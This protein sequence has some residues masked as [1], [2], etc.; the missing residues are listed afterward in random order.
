MRACVPVRVGVYILGLEGWSGLK[1]A[2]D[3]WARRASRL[4]ASDGDASR[5][6][7]DAVAT[8]I[9]A[10]NERRRWSTGRS[11]AGSDSAVVGD[12]DGGRTRAVCSSSAREARGE[13]AREARVSATRGRTNGG[14]RGRD[15][16]GACGGGRARGGGW[17]R[18]GGDARAGTRTAGE[19]ARTRERRVEWSGVVSRASRRGSRG[20]VRAD[21]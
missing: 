8:R 12:G 19:R 2:E 7:I 9:D 21:D 1:I 18:W 13:G 10:R 20:A 4:D 16:E 17:G 15:A 5:R 3:E 14:G 11:D 6:R